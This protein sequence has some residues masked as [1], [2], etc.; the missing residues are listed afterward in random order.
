MNFRYQPQGAFSLR[1]SSRF[2]CSFAPA[3]GAGCAIDDGLTVA[4]LS[5]DG[6]EPRAVKLQ[7]EGASVVLDAPDAAA[8]DQAL[9]IFSLDV[10]ATPLRDIAARDEVVARLLAARPGFRPPI[11]GSPYEAAIWG[12]LA[13][14]IS[15][16]QAVN[17]RTRMAETMGSTLDA[18]GAR[19]A[20]A[21]S[22]KALLSRSRFDGLPDE[23]WARLQAVARAA[24]EGALNLAALRALPREFA[25]AQLRTIRGVGEWT[26]THILVRGTGTLDEL[27]VAEPRV[28]RAIELEYGRAD[29]SVAERWRPLRTW[30]SILLVSN[31]EARGRWVDPR[32]RALRG[33]RVSRSSSSAPASAA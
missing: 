29:V 2:W 26:A 27:P 5:D 23:K 25:L 11:F 33:K 30:V 12:V 14:R 15:M 19:Y 32:D 3:S 7:Q 24:E 8:R 4:F 10:D 22:P 13:Q 28:L 17:L 18:F 6:F 1:E 31:L 9:R 20:L 21:P 16:K